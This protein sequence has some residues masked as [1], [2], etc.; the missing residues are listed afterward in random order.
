VTDQDIREPDTFASITDNAFHYPVSA[1]DDGME[2]QINTRAG[3]SGTAIFN[4]AIN[5]THCVASYKAGEVNSVNI[6]ALNPNACE[7]QC[8][9]SVNGRLMEFK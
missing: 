2:V 8:V 3:P 9:V 1:L 6:P 7:V 4:L 5:H